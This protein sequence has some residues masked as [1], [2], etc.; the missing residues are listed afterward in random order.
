MSPSSLVLISILVLLTIHLP[1]FESKKSIHSHQHHHRRFTFVSRPSPKNWRSS[2]EDYDQ[3]RFRFLSLSCHQKKNREEEEDF[4][5]RCC[6]PRRRDQRIE[7]IPIECQLDGTSLLIATEVILNSTTELR[8]NHHH[9]EGQEGQEGKPIH[10]PKDKIHVL[11]PESGRGPS[12]PPTEEQIKSI[13]E[14]EAKIAQMNQEVNLTSTTTLNEENDI[15]PTTT[16]TR[17]QVQP[18]KEEQVGQVS[19]QPEEMVKKVSNQVQSETDQDRSESPI[20]NPIESKPPP[21]QNVKSVDHHHLGSLA[22]MVSQVYGQGDEAKATFFYQGGAAGAC[23]N[24]N[25]DEV[26]LVAL[27]PELYSNGEHCGQGVLIRN[28]ENGKSVIAKVQDMCP[29]CPT[30]HSLDLSTGAYDAIGAQATG[31]LPIEWGFI[32]Q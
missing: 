13:Q 24:T 30:S 15:K 18:S 27:P 2:L 16:T 7:Q 3:Y 29:G 20:P 32:D 22:T 8:K 31:V 23:G 10:V 28:K 6:H 17:I 9:Q 25:S 19:S 1:T 12:D 5:Q 11:Q 4:Y 21:I 14:A 26:P